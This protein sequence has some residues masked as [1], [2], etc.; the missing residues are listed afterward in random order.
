M[1][2]RLQTDFE[3]LSADNVEVRNVLTRLRD[4]Y[5]YGEVVSSK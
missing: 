3:R 5:G 4:A 1:L 2:N